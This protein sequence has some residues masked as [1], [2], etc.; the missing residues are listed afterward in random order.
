MLNASPITSVAVVEVV[1]ANPSGHASFSTPTLITSSASLASGEPGFPVMAIRRLP[2][3]FKGAITF[4]ISDELPL[5]EINRTM[6]FFA[7]IPKS[8]CM[9]SAALI[10]MVGVPVD[11]S[12]EAIL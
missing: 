8:P 4:I 6:S 3:F 5:F 1:G 2:I 10:K 7:I 11:A 9:A 12:D